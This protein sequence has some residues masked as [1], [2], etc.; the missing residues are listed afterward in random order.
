[1]SGRLQ[2]KTAKNGARVIDDTYNANP[3]SVRAAIDVLMQAPSPRVLVLG[4]MGEVGSEG[5]QFHV[6]IG[7]YA[8]GRGIETMFTLG[9][10]AGNATSA[11]GARGRHFDNIDALNKA[12]EAAAVPQSTVLVKGSRFMK[13]ER[14]V[15][16]LAGEQSTGSQIK[17]SH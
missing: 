10:L 1:V 15:Q 16:H 14:V 6:E 4:D 11:F 17:E 2:S 3:D 7:A 5:R 13:M 8:R 12:V 9:E